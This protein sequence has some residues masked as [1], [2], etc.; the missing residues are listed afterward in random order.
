MPYSAGINMTTE[1]STNRD[2]YRFIGELTKQQATSTLSLEAYLT[3]LR[4]LARMHSQQPTI[5]VAELAGLL[6]QAFVQTA[7]ADEPA[8]SGE[9]ASGYSEW[10]QR[11]EAQ[12]RD[13][14]AMEE[15]GTFQ[16]E[17]RYF[18]ASAPGGGYWY[19][20]DP[21]TFLE[22]AAA[23]SFGGWEEGDDTGR[24]YVP[25]K[26]AVIDASGEL[27][28]VDPRDLHD[29]ITALPAL[30]WN[31]LVDFLDAGQSYE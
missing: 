10:E 8:P 3:N 20:F 11:L 14:R 28:S 2:L 22:C 23:G 17:M 25:G 19:N 6:Q 30:T 24:I 29:P 16:D 26:V 13:L 18:G 27:T 9:P 1:L 7:G 12:L 21:R 15:A 4:R 5:S 31:E